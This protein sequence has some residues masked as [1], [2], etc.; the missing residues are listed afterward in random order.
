MNIKDMSLMHANFQFESVILL[1]AA[2]HSYDGPYPH[3][4]IISG[5]GD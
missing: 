2:R 4:K 3:Y 5:E 1:L